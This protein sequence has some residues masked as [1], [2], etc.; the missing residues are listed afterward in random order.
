MSHAP[1][2][3]SCVP[4]CHL[5]SQICVGST[6]VGERAR[7]RRMTSQ[8][9]ANSPM[10]HRQHDPTLQPVEM[11]MILIAGAALASMRDASMELFR[12]GHMSVMGEWFSEPLVSLSGLDRADEDTLPQHLPPPSP[13]PP[14][15]RA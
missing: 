14:S 13:A 12:A 5:P 6:S 3:A 7:R 4:E 1:V 11:R 9:S 8:P 2:A 10:L 15:R